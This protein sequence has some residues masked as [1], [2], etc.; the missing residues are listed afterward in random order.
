MKFY[1]MLVSQHIGDVCLYIIII[2]A[3]IDYIGVLDYALKAIIGSGIW[4]GFRV[5]GDYFT[6]KIK[7]SLNHQK[8]DQP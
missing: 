5:L 4:F 1:L 3:G 8:Q 2:L 7:R 6:T